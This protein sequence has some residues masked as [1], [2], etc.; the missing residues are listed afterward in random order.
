MTCILLIAVK[1]FKIMIVAEM[2][3]CPL[4]EE[5]RTVV[6]LHWVVTNIQHIASLPYAW[7]NGYKNSLKDESPNLDYLLYVT[8]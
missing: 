2:L 6:I 5:H 7:H 8:L 3:E 4:P 1:Y